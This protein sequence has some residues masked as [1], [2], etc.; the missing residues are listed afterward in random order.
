MN[1]AAL[2][3]EARTVAKRQQDRL[4]KAIDENRDLTAEEEAAE[5]ED[6]A[7]VAR[8]TGQIKRAETLNETL[9]ALGEGGTQAAP[10]APAQP[11]GRQPGQQ[12][13][14]LDTGGF[15]SMA[16]FATAVRCANPAAGGAFRVDDRL[17]APTNVHMEQGDA[18]GSYLVPAEFRQQIVDLV[19]AD[20]DPMVNLF[21][22]DPTASNRV[23][24]LG[25]E[26]TPWGTSGIQAYWRAE[27]DQMKPS[28]MQLTP[29]ETVL[30]ELYAFV[31]ATEELLEDAPRIATLLT[32]KAAA[33]IRW[34]LVEA[35]MFANG[36]GKPLGFF[37][38]R[39]LIT[40]PKK[41]GQVADTIIAENIANMFARMIM[42]SQAS[43]VANSDIMPQLM[44]LA[45]ANGVPLWMPNYAVS[46]GGALL[47]RPIIFNEH[48]M[49]LGDKGD[50]M[51]VNPNGYESFRKQSGVSFADSI[52]LYFDYNIRAFRWTF[53]AGGQPVLTQPVAPAKGVTTKSH[54]VALDVR[55]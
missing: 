12:R 38:S 15:A 54:F 21:N 47:G 34:K 44:T 22:P 53:R 41:A 16:D 17:A 50:L 18:A 43:W 25:D 33:A 26:T 46:P 27:A 9:T 52:H 14:Q 11:A 40:V 3:N 24:G 8:L 28:R 30:N 20:D 36:V 7:T 48:S 37:N 6:A 35:F 29:R 32:T 23:I 55:A 5:T 51:F 1:L 42:P 19:F 10:P 49:T 2:K 39:A 13:A 4:K 31:L 45:G